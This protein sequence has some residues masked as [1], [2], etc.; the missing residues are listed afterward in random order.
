MYFLHG[1]NGH[2][3]HM[4][5]PVEKTPIFNPRT[6]TSVFLKVLNIMYSLNLDLVTTSLILLYLHTYVFLGAL[7]SALFQWNPIQGLVG[8]GE[9][10]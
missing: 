9:G 7:C 10:E 3:Y 6:K 2:Y 8:N 4:T 1:R 5:W